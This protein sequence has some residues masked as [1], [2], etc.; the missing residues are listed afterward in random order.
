MT[1]NTKQSIVAVSPEFKAFVAETQ[2]AFVAPGKTVDLKPASEKEV[3]NALLAFVTE[4]RTQSRLVPAMTEDL[5]P[6]TA[7]VIQ[8]PA[9][10][11]DG[12]PIMVPEEYDAFALEMKREL[13]LRA[14]VERANT[15]KAANASLE[16]QLAE[17]RAKLAALENN[18]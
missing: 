7:E 8:I 1:T 11:E 9:I 16:A 12:E 17:L 3:C 18:G 14:T 5:D 10:G 6:E 15:L 13:A 2:A 4:H